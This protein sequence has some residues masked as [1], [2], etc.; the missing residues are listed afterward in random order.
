MGLLVKFCYEY[1]LN[2]QRRLY[3]W[4]HFE[5]N[6]LGACRYEVYNFLRIHGVN[7]RKARRSF[8]V[9]LRKAGVIDLKNVPYKRGTFKVLKKRMLS[10]YFLA[11]H[12]STY[13]QWLVLFN[14]CTY[15]VSERIA[16]KLDATV[17]RAEKVWFII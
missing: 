7:S 14:E 13:N 8:L 3:F 15:V 11:L 2:K 6:D 17:E 1:I 16:R 4:W 10:E 12:D 9:E 5:D